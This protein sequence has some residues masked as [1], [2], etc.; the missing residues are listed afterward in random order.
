[1]TEL[2]FTKFD[3]LLP[4]VVQDAQTDKLLMVGFMN[5]EALEVTRASKQ[6]TFYSRS[7][8]CLLYTSPSPRDS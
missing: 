3:G 7:K 4:V 6:V 8:S 5:A 1:M 2:N